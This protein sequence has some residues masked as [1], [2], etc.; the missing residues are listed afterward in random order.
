MNI[1]LDNSAVNWLLRNGHN[2]YQ[3]AIQKK[4]VLMIGEYVVLEAGA[5]PDADKRER[6]FTAINSL[7]I[8]VVLCNPFDMVK[9]V[10]V[11]ISK[12]ELVVDTMTRS[13]GALLLVANPLLARQEYVQLECSAKLQEFGDFDS[14]TVRAA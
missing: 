5:T 7:G 3:R 14:A 11:A 10:V 9:R 1:Y 2:D 13:R 4:Y 12:G 8:D 6:L